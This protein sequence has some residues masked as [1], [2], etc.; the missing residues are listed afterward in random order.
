MN[1]QWSSATRLHLLATA[2]LG[3]AVLTFAV[4][5]AV[6][7]LEVRLVRDPAQKSPPTSTSP[8]EPVPAGT[9]EPQEPWVRE[10]VDAKPYFALLGY[11]AS[12]FR[13]QGGWIDAWI[14]VEVEGQKTLLGK[15][16]GD[17][18]RTDAEGLGRVMT[19]PSGYLLWVRQ[20][21]H[22]AEVWDLALSYNGQDGNLSGSVHEKRITPPQP[23][24][25]AGTEGSGIW[26]REGGGFIPPTKE[27]LFVLDGFR[28]RD[29]K[30]ITRKVELKCRFMK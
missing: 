13:Y 18:L 28:N 15:E 9:R 26:S 12:L 22:G 21:E 7:M 2:C 16:L 14:E 3:A 24:S 25:G 19:A 5:A 23:K 11:D 30:E 10:I 27:G 1:D 29:G 6:G 17:T 20:K 4:L 8:R